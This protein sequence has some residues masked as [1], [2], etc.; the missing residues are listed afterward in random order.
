M[1]HLIDVT[2][3]NTITTV[4]KDYNGKLYECKIFING[5]VDP[6]QKNFNYFR[7]VIPEGNY[8]AQSLG[9][10]LHTRL[11]DIELIK[12]DGEHIGIGQ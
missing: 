7:F 11:N 8:T 1:A 12:D 3:V 5:L 6:Y 2:M 4:I 10:Y 9:E